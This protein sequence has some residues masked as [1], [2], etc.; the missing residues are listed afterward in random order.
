[1]AREALAKG[2]KAAVDMSWGRNAKSK[3]GSKSSKSSKSSS[4]VKSKAEVEATYALLY[5]LSSAQYPWM[6]DLAIAK[7]AMAMLPQHAEQ[8][9]KTGGKALL[10]ALT[11]LVRFVG[12]GSSSK[13]GAGRAKGSSGKGKGGAS[14]NDRA[15]DPSGD[16][17]SNMTAQAEARYSKV[18]Q[19]AE[20]ERDA[21]GKFCEGLLA[22]LRPVLTQLLN[23]KEDEA[24]ALTLQLLH[25]LLPHASGKF[26]AAFVGVYPEIYG[27]G[28]VYNKAG[29]DGSAD[30]STGGGY[31]TK[32]A[33]H[34]LFHAHE[35]EVVRVQVYRTMAWLHDHHPFVLTGDDGSTAEENAQ[36]ADERNK[37][38]K[39]VLRLAIQR[40]LVLGLTDGS[41]E[42][43]QGVVLEGFWG[44]KGRL[45]EQPARRLAELLE[46]LHVPE[47]TAERRWVGLTSHLLLS[48]SLNSPDARQKFYKDSLAHGAEYKPMHV[49]ASWSGQAMQGSLTTPLLSPQHPSQQQWRQNQ[50][51]ASQGGSQVVQTQAHAVSSQYGSQY[52]Q[53]SQRIDGGFGYTQGGGAALATQTRD[54][55]QHVGGMIRMTQ[56][57]A[58]G[59]QYD[60][61][62]WTQSQAIG[63][64]GWLGGGSSSGG[65][66][67]AV[68]GS[69]GAEAGW[70]GGMQLTQSVF[71]VGTGGRYSS[72]GKRRRSPM[73]SMMPPPS[74]PRGNPAAKRKISGSQSQSFTSFQFASQSSS[75][76]VSVPVPRISAYTQ[77]ESSAPS[78]SS[79]SASDTNGSAGAAATGGGGGD[80]GAAGSGS[81]SSGG[82]AENKQRWGQ[83]HAKERAQRKAEGQR[84][85]QAQ[86]QK[87]V[88]YRRYRRGEL[89]D[90]QIEKQDLIGPL[91]QLS[92]LD[93]AGAGAE[94]LVGLFQ[95][96]YTS[97][98]R[99]EADIDGQLA[100][101]NEFGDDSDDDGEDEGAAVMAIGSRYRGDEGSSSSSQEYQPLTNGLIHNGLR[102]RIRSGVCDVLRRSRSPPV[103][104]AL[105]RCC[106]AVNRRLE[107]LHLSGQ[108]KSDG[109]SA[110]GSS[111]DGGRAKKGAK[112][113]A[114]DNGIVAKAGA[115]SSDLSVPWLSLPDALFTTTSTADETGEGNVA[116]VVVPATAIMLLE[117]QLLRRRRYE[118]IETKG[119]S[120]AVTVGTLTG[121]SLS[122][123]GSGSAAKAGG[124]RSRGG[125][126][127][128]GG[129]G[130][131]PGT[132][133]VDRLLNCQRIV[134]PE[135]AS[136]ASDSSSGG[137]RVS[138]GRLY[139]LYE[140]TGDVDAMALLM[141]RLGRMKITARA[142]QAELQQDFKRAEAL[143]GQA[144]RKYVDHDDE[145]G[146]EGGED[147]EEEGAEPD[148][149]ESDKWDD[150]LLR[151]Q[152]VLCDW[153]AVLDN[154]LSIA[155]PEAEGSPDPMR[156][157]GEQPRAQA[158]R[159]VHHYVEAAGRVR[160]VQSGVAVV[161]DETAEQLS[162]F[163][164]KSLAFGNTS[165]A[166][167]ADESI[168][169]GS[170]TG[171]AVGPD[172]ADRHWLRTELA[173]EVAFGKFARQR[174]LD[175]G[176]LTA[177]ARQGLATFVA[178]LCAL[179]RLALAAR[180]QHL[181]RLQIFTEVGAVCG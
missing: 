145:G 85:K 153:D 62:Q 114:V 1:V 39:S 123:G 101:D 19:G 49:N 50:Q 157:W 141:G 16:A 115:I 90:V 117:E 130:A 79:Q 175:T 18:V 149:A 43:R 8:R 33:L 168:G 10:P 5:Q 67:A 70:G 72:P 22:Q 95:L 11:L 161:V 46:V 21:H 121:S 107:H 124:G 76:M 154:V 73:K 99:T 102:M 160:Q 93:P 26:I 111:A 167:S 133:A 15:G 47:P 131:N 91:A 53:F 159:L 126:G 109:A 17:M 78:N 134:L 23:H 98:G 125:S 135:A 71:S 63:G 25:R 122:S 57:N 59:S 162:S 172:D 55:S 68:S 100:E 12:K 83:Y 164:T 24:N 89:P 137:E 94:I 35:M 81:S 140:S 32:L 20:D 29:R 139:E 169:A 54:V 56:D 180:A 77:Q 87:V 86:R 163:L 108:I 147:Q 61:S 127:A 106:L 88:M 143:Y 116:L 28:G 84:K 45:H 176:R 7:A 177:Y 64:G 9:L 128:G 142:L 31:F 38:C 119:G 14:A 58:S 105:H 118:K 179:P 104:S 41:E 97:L 30:E 181:N 110:R 156:L 155:D 74:R 146:D 48:L 138:G 6:V 113:T 80:T 75:Q 150:R 178:K 132:L 166:A 174:P 66:S 129:G 2:A 92:L 82:S 152:S 37:Q 4:G 171:A 52:S 120:A 27:A 42:V 36:R 96:L 65:S 51:S 69:G 170:S 60:Q 173:L 165:S 151:C 112:E 148:R 34:P 136:G 40:I 3:S 144:L 103:V 13:K 158:R 44:R